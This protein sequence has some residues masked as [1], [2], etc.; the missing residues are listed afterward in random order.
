VVSSRP[1]ALP[2]GREPAVHIDQEA[3]WAPEPVWT[4]V[5][6]FHSFCSHLEH[7]ASVKR[8]VSLLF[9]NLRQSVGLLG[10]GIRPSPGR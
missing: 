8:F 10:R 1:A 3:G 9:L 4:V 2:A 5:I 7:R 6:F